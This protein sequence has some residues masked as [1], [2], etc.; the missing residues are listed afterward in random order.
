MSDEVEMRGVRDMPAMAMSLG[1][2]TYNKTGSW[3]NM[4]PVLDGEKC[5][6]CMLCWKFCPD[7]CISAE[8]PPV[9]DYDYCK[10]CGVCANECP[11]DAI[12]MIEGATPPSEGAQTPE[13]AATP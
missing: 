11:V 13:P 1:R 4:T 10:G 8:V 12:E 6:G 7:V 9:I 5:N 2:M 3:R